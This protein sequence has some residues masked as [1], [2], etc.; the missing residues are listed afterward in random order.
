VWVEEG[1]FER[2]VGGEEQSD[3]WILAGDLPEATPDAFY[4]RV[5]A[6]LEK[7]GFAKEVW[8]ICESAYADASRGGRLGIDPVVYLKM[9]TVGFFE[10][11]PSQRAIASRCADSLSIRGYLGYSLTEATPDHSSMTVIRDRLSLEQLEAIHQVLLK[12][13]RAHGLLRGRKLGIDSSVIEANA[14]LRA[15]ESRNTA[16]SYWDYVKRLAEAAGV[17]SN[18]MKAVRR[19]DRQREG[20]KTSNQEWQNPHDPEAKVGRTKDGACDMIYKPEHITDLESGAIVRAEVRPGDAADNDATLCERVM[21]AVAT[22]SEV[23]PDVPV[24]NFGSELCGDEGYFAIEQIAQLQSCQVRTIIADPQ[25]RQRKPERAS[26]EHRSALSR[27]TRAIQSRSGKA[28]LRARGQH[29]ERSFCHLLDHGG[30][31]R[32][33]LRGCDKL[34]KRQLGGAFAYNLSL[35]LR[36][37]FGVGTPKQ[38]LAT[39]LCGLL[40][41]LCWLTK[42]LAAPTLHFSKRQPPLRP[43]FDSSNRTQPFSSSSIKMSRISTGC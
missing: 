27:A 4:R 41:T 10:N 11:L 34:T 1:M 3:F 35:L 20:R 31:R 26:A 32:A 42:L 33:T 36:H 19:F 21:E 13:L 39:G 29:L 23:A 37:L 43:I 18:D 14:S 25:R 9:L 15:L 5:N 40:A 6:T 7:I 28:L 12:A 24:E 8:A 30:L 16:E 22:L 17:D 38:A 2:R